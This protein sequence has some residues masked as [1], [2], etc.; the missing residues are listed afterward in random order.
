[1]K[2]KLTTRLS[3]F[4]HLWSSKMID[5]LKK[6]WSRHPQQ[7]SRRPGEHLT[8][9]F[10]F[11]ELISGHKLLIKSVFQYFWHLILYVYVCQ[12]PVAW[13][14]GLNPASQQSTLVN[15][16]GRKFNLGSQT[17]SELARS[18]S[19][20][21]DGRCRTH[22]RAD[23]RNSIDSWLNR[24]GTCDMSDNDAISVTLSETERWN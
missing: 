6:F 3:V 13:K 20:R 17:D 9:L 4:L 7:H 11:T 21:E 23:S 2:W 8:N 12:R 22:A 16:R 10:S 15:S 18:W 1:M 24:V 19:R 5:I 14:P